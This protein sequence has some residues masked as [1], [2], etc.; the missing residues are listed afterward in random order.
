MSKFNSKKRPG[1]LSHCAV[2][3]LIL[4]LAIIVG[5]CQS[6]RPQAM[7]NSTGTI[8]SDPVQAVRE[9]VHF[10][11]IKSGENYSTIF[12]SL[13]LT[14]RHQLIEQFSQQIPT[15]K[16]RTGTKYAIVPTESTHPD[17]VIFQSN[18]REYLVC[19]SDPDGYKLI[20]RIL[21]QRSRPLFYQGEIGSSLWLGMSTENISPDLIMRFT[22]IFQW[23]I[24]FLVDTRQGDQFA[25]MAERIEICDINGCWKSA[26]FGSII[27]ASYTQV[28]SVHWACRFSPD[29]L[30]TG[31]YTRTGE[32]LAKAFLK[33]P[34]NYRR[35]S[36]T[37]SRG[38]MHPI[39]KIIRPHNGVDFAA[40]RGTPVVASGDGTI[41][42]MKYQKRGMGRYIK[43]RHTNNRYQTIYGHLSRYA[44]GLETGMRV[45][46]N[47]VIGY[48]GSTGMSSGNH[49]HYTFL[50]DGI[51]VDPM[52][53]PN[54]GLPP[55][56]G[57]TL[58][59]FRQQV[60]ECESL[61]KRLLQETPPDT[62]STINQLT[63]NSIALQE[64]ME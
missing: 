47:Q 28:D 19:L 30:H 7:A 29:S 40:A 46:Q 61:W 18:A 1:R 36:S 53:I 59:R 56:A 24:D 50:I 63:K 38:R 39:L 42:A 15:R 52:S 2:P 21:P 4:L 43:I 57:V 51:A 11:E 54:P 32:P 8:Q 12:A 62:N 25:L 9:P 55:L 23:D 3:P 6:E 35:I 33:S 64:K 22:D 13:P 37:F 27:G 45:I 41:V 34:L 5:G 48:V 17:S 60:Q 14:V 26:G 31:Y 49:L 10:K 16:L 44:K 20:D 58:A